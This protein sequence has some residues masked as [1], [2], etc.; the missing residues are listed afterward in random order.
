MDSVNY[1]ENRKE[2]C[3]K[4]KS[5]QFHEDQY[6]RHDCSTHGIGKRIF[7]HH[8]MGSSSSKIFCNFSMLF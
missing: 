2:K 3:Y 4:K 7:K 5:T 6:S 1:K 8:I